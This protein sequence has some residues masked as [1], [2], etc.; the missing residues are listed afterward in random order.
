MKRELSPS[1]FGGRQNNEK[2]PVDSSPLAAYG[3]WPGPQ[4]RQPA[5]PAYLPLELKALEAQ[6]VS[7][8]NQIQA[9]ERRVAHVDAQMIEFGKTTTARFER[10]AHAISR[11]EE[12]AKLSTQDVQSKFA[13]TAAKFNERRMS[14]VK[15]QEMVD[16]HNQ[17]VSSFENRLTHLQRVLTEQEMQIMSANSLLEE[18]RHGLALRARRNQP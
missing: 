15:I 5:M 9:L 16:R 3:D 7:F 10:V 14:D 17:V 11:L 8:K 6:M 18:T 4:N 13:A 12:S 2:S 1:L